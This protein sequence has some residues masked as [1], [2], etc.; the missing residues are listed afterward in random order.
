MIKYDSTKKAALVATYINVFLLGLDEEEV[1]SDTIVF[2]NF[3][4]E[5]GK[6]NILSIPRIQKLK[7]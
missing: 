7:K 3:N 1:R 6:L 4:N 5:N 2:L